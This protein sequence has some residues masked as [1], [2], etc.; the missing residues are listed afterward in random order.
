MKWNLLFTLLCSS[1]ITV[2]QDQLSTSKKLVGISM[3]AYYASIFAHSKSVQNTAGA[4]PIGVEL[5]YTRQNL[6]EK[7]WQQCHCFPNMGLGIHYF[8]YD[9]PILGK[10]TALYYLLEPQFKLSNSTK[11]LVSSHSGIAYLTNP[12]HPI[13]N[14]N[15][16]SY[17][18]HISAYVGLGLGL[19]YAVSRWQIALLGYFL[20]ISNGG[21]K[22]PNKGINWPSVG[23]RL[24]YNT[25]QYQ[26]P[27]YSKR[28][29]EEDKET[30]SNLDLF[31][32][33]KT[34]ATGEKARFFI[35]GLNYQLTRKISLLNALSIGTEIIWDYALK[36]RI[37]RE[38]LDVSYT[39][40]GI[41]VGHEFLLG[42]FGFGQQLGI[43]PY[44][45]SP[46]FSLFYH[47]WGLTYR[48]NDFINI[49]IRLLAHRQVA[50]FLDFRIGYTI[51]FKKN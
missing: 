20:H 29:P 21:I 28:K 9:S 2:A 50:N 37:R 15:N 45:P 8:D 1:Y 42:K 17:S 23:L 44:S 47:R 31:L 14:P 43:Y 11:L 40:I 22:D 24:T 35:V 32:S 10:S 34:V 25:S 38:H 46:Y 5:L 41:L 48:I 27:R 39:R 6:E 19:Q 16:M 12:Y 33:S 18:T 36:E 26:L 30:K 7:I 3:G 51:N 13:S 4:N 49:G